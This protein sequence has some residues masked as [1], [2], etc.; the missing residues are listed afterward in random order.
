MGESVAGNN[1]ASPT[2]P[3]PQDDIQSSDK[4]N[5]FTSLNADDGD[6]DEDFGLMVSNDISLIATVF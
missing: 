3:P 1:V 5:G 4:A 2:S 6:N